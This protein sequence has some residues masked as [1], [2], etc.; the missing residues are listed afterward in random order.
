MADLD[1][2]IQRASAAHGSGLLD[3]T[4]LVDGR[5]DHADLVAASTLGWWLLAG[6]SGVHTVRLPQAHEAVFHRGGVVA[7]CQRRG[8][9]IVVVLDGDADAEQLGAGDWGPMLA[10]VVPGRCVVID[11]LAATVNRPPEP[12]EHGRRYTWVSTL[13]GRTGRL[14]PRLRAVA[15]SDATRC[16]Y[17]FVDNVHRWAMASDALA[18]VSVT[19]GG[20]ER[21]FDRLHVVVMDDGRGIIDSVLHDSSVEGLPAGIAGD[22]TTLL[23]HFMAKAFGDRGVPRHNGHGLHVAQLLAKAW[24]GRVDLLSTDVRDGTVHRARSTVARGIEGCDSFALPGAR[25]TLVEVTLNLTASPDH[26][27][28]IT[29]DEGVE[30][31]TLFPDLVS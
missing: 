30:Q 14:P 4:G 21:S 8:I 18:V 10:P 23:E 7:A 25:G 11:E 9:D 20:G 28:V 24:I 26:R 16:L 2:V 3:L 1:E 22:L 5:F 15:G 19:R 29:N 31:Q 27:D 17:E 6:G 13:I 12:D